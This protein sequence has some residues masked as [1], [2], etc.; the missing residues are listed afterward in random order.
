MSASSP[1]TSSTRERSATRRSVATASST[2]SR[3]I[4]TIAARSTD[5]IGDPPVELGRE[6]GTFVVD[7]VED[8][9]TVSL[10]AG[11]A[12][13]YDAAGLAPAREERLRNLA[14]DAPLHGR[15]AHDAL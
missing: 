2:P 7:E 4:A 5:G 8:E 1:S 10:R 13:V 3:S 14:H 15:V 6:V 9:L 12:G 11:Q